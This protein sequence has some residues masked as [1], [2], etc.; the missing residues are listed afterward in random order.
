MSPY[1]IRALKDSV[2]ESTGATK[3]E[4]ATASAL[5]LLF[6]TLVT[7]GLAVRTDWREG[8]KLRIELEEL[9]RKQRPKVAPSD[10]E[11]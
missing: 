6:S 7:L 9:R 4:F 1:S 3:S 10:A 5:I 2:G 11:I 8:R